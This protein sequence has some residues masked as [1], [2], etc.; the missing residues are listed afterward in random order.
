MKYY[1][2]KQY[3]ITDCRAAYVATVFKQYSLLL[4]G[5]EVHLQQKDITVM[6]DNKMLI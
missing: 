2:I 1:D 6:H 4:Y 3:D 5:K